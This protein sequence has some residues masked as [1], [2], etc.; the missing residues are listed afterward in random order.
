[1]GLCC[2]G[3]TFLFALIDF[4]IIPSSLYSRC[5]LWLWDGSGGRVFATFGLSDC[6]P[7]LK[8]SCDFLFL[9]ARCEGFFLCFGWP[10]NPSRLF[11]RENAAVWM[12]IFLTLCCFFLSRRPPRVRILP[13][14]LL[15][16]STSIS[17]HYTLSKA[18]TTGPL[19]AKSCK[20]LPFILTL[21]PEEKP[22]T[23]VPPFFSPTS[24]T[25]LNT[26][27]FINLH[28][29]LPGPAEGV[30]RFAGRRHNSL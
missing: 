27:P 2:R 18:P 4:A 7:L 14:P 23:E 26:P 15:P 9:A 29:P 25:Q 24:L 8:F 28:P 22:L 19:S 11:P 17:P 3:S 6:R 1:M 12:H 16:L 10:S 5:F 13:H 30:L 20:C 21:R